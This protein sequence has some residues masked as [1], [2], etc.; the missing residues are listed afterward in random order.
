V[1]RGRGGEHYRNSENFFPDLY[2][3]FQQETGGGVAESSQ[4]CGYGGSGGGGCAGLI[5]VEAPI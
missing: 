1:E 3:G 4:K 2:G 5:D